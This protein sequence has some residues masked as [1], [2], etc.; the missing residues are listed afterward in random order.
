MAEVLER[1]GERQ[2]LGDVLGR[3]REDVGGQDVDQGLVGMERGLVGVGDLGRRLVLEP[4]LDQHPVLAPVEVV[5]AQ[6]PD[7]GDVLDV[8]HLDARGT[9]GPG[10]SGRPAGTSAGSR[11]GRSGTRSGRRCTSGP[12]PAPAARPAPRSGSG[13]CG[14]GGSWRHR[15]WPWP[16]RGRRQGDRGYPT[17]YSAPMRRRL[18]VLPSSSCSSAPVGAVPAG[19]V[20]RHG[21]D[22][23]S[24]EPTGPRP[25]AHA[26]TPGARRSSPSSSRR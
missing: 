17:V 12:G 11:R 14:G 21:A 10:G 18:V 5:V 25:G 16:M 26:A 22:R 15:R 20:R 19:G 4:G 24:G 3:P 7:V 23:C 9:A 8:E 1:L 13:C 2:H 6:V